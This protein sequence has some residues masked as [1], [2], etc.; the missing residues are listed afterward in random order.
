[1]SD[2]I[3]YD[4]AEDRTFPAIVYALYL[5]GIVSGVTVLL[6]L[7]LAYIGRDR[8]GPKMRSH[9]T[10]LIRTCWLWIVWALIGL[11]LVFWG[12]IFSLIL[13]GLPFLWLGWAIFGLIH[14]WFAVRAI[15]GVVYLARDEAYPRPRTWLV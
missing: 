15:V 6:G 7:V 1:M 2:T 5:I 14:T 11:A 10:F 3:S 4:A 8:C 9:Y 12:A 13:I